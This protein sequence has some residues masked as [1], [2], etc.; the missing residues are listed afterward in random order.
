MEELTVLYVGL[1]RT[2]V[3]R[4]EE[5]L[6]LPAGTTV[7]ELLR[8]LAGQY[9]ERFRDALFASDGSLLPNVMVLLD[10]ESIAHR[11]GLAT[12]LAGH[13]RAHLLVTMTAIEGG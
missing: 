11:E 12:P 2:V 4:A 13:R 10:E 5:R 3:P 8:E 6:A 1:I 9:G 7:G